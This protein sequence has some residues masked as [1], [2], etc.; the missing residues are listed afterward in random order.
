[1]KET[2]ITC[3]T[4]IPISTGN[5]N[6]FNHCIGKYH[7]YSLPHGITIAN[8]NDKHYDKPQKEDDLSMEIIGS[9]EGTTTMNCIHN[10]ET[11]NQCYSDIRL[12]NYDIPKDTINSNI[13]E[14]L[15]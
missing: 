3:D 6:R 15:S 10:N 1:M 5:G 13:L 14:R 11:C 2:R 4:E 9:T 12:R 8:D 7:N